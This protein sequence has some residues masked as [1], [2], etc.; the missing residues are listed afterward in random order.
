MAASA[1]L[2]DI[3]PYGVLSADTPIATALLVIDECTSVLIPLPA[4][5]SNTLMSPL[6]AKIATVC[7]QVLIANDVDVTAS[8]LASPSYANATN[9]PLAPS[10]AEQKYLDPIA[11]PIDRIVC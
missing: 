10:N 8:E 7:C 6:S 4:L 9:L 5:S 1:I 2:P 3:Y 11:W